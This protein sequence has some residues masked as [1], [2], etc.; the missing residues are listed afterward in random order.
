MVTSGN[1]PMINWAVSRMVAGPG[2]RLGEDRPNVATPFSTYSGAISSSRAPG[3]VALKMSSTYRRS[4]F[5]LASDMVIR[6]LPSS[7][8]GLGGSWPRACGYALRESEDR[9]RVGRRV[10]PRGRPGP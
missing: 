4:G 7:A 3:C 10:P 5:L 1:W 6:F 2:T 9:L 8:C